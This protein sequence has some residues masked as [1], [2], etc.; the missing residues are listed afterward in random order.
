METIKRRI[1]VL[2]RSLCRWRLLG[3]GSGAVMLAALVMAAGQPSPDLADIH[4]RSITVVND[5]GIP[6]C[7]MMAG[8]YGGVLEL[9]NNIALTVQKASANLESVEV[10]RTGKAL[11]FGGAILQLF[12]HKGR[13]AIRAEVGSDDGVVS[14]YSTSSGRKLLEL[15]T[16][17]GGRMLVAGERYESTEYGPGGPGPGPNQLG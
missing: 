12:N 17:L 16:S 6:V 4:A 2:E 8:E 11:T 13:Q 1:E 9:L 3:L 14:M 5:K 15:S 7:R 10:K